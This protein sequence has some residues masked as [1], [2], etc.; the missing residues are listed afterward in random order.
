MDGL[1]VVAG[2]DPATAG[3][4][5]IVVLGV[6]RNTRMRWVLDVHN[7]KGMTPHRLQET[8]TLI[9]AKFKVNEWRIE[10]N[11]LQQMISQD[12]RLRQIIQQGGGRI[13]EHHTGQNKWDPQFGVMSLAPLFLGAMQM[14]KRN[15]IAIPNNSR[16]RGVKSLVDQLISWS[17]QTVGKT[18]LVMALWFADLGARKLLDV[19]TTQTHMKN[20]WASSGQQ[21]KRRVIDLNAQ[22]ENDHLQYF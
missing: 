20:K 4:T 11:G 18:D 22:M 19:N 21:A 7:I 2:L 13:V 14:P 10:K 5:G 15:L 17:P 16:H 3:H 8:I 1:Y 6:D 12:D 9:Q